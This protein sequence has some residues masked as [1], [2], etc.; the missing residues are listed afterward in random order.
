[1][2][3]D[4]KKLMFFLESKA[5][6]RIRVRFYRSSAQRTATSLVQEV[7]LVHTRN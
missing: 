3:K 4:T 5:Q 6:R 2:S 7:F 1:M